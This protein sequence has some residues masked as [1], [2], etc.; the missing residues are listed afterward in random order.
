[1]LPEDER[2]NG[3]EWSES[4]SEITS[5]IS[6]S[7]VWTDTSSANDRSS[8]R[9]LILQ[10]AKARM[11]QNKSHV[12]DKTD[13]PIAEESF[14]DKLDKNAGSKSPNEFVE[15]ELELD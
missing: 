2:S 5:V 11:K 3:N 10:M 14:E 13:A 6:G 7:S 1:M 15:E 9:A 12:E 4:G 8:R